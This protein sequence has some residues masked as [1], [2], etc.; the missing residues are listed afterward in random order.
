MRQS[1][2]YCSVAFTMK[3]VDIVPIEMT[4]RA[5]VFGAQGNHEA[6]QQARASAF[7]H[8]APC[9]KRREEKDA[10]GL[11]MFFIGALK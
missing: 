1:D 4:G 10:T 3:T 5:S 6:T 11:M 2:Y 8:V 9:P 7:L